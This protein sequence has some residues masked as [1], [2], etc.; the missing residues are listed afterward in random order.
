LIKITFQTEREINKT[1]DGEY[2]PGKSD[3]LIPEWINK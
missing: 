3:E 2:L 1:A